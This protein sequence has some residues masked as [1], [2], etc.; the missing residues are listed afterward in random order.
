L[1][2]DA[3]LF[4][5]SDADLAPIAY[6][7]MIE[8][9]RTDVTLYQ[10]KG[11]ILGNRL[12]HPLR[13]HPAEAQRKLQEFIDQERSTIA[14][15]LES[16]PGYARRDRW[17]YVEIDKSSRDP[18]K[19]TIDIPEEAIRFFEGSILGAA[20][21]NAWAATHQNELRRRYAVLL[22]Q[23][24]PRGQP[25]D[26]RS[27]RHLA[28]LSQDFSGALGIA[29]GLMADRRGYSAGAVQAH[30]DRARDLMPSDA[31]KADQSGFFHLRGALRFDLGDRAG[32]IQDFET[33]ISI[34]PLP[35]NRA[36]KPLED[37][38]RTA[39]NEGALKALQ[40]RIKRPRQ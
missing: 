31:G 2:R 15:T 7:H 13:T 1:P 24:L 40:G 9:L 16:Y 19:V 21:P 28:A 29:E 36:L 10:S 32:A 23:G 38:Y 22:A 35:D 37:L 34:W 11:L 33:A 25:P 14:L 8:N 5:K 26:A 30:L 3:L 39:G 27:S 17:L 12:F 18:S 20:E 6:F 4:V